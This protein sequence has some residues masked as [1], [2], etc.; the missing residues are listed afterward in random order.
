[1][2]VERRAHKHRIS[3]LERQVQQL[4]ALS[5]HLLSHGAPVT[6]SQ[7]EEKTEQHVEAGSEPAPEKAVNNA[8]SAEVKTQTDPA[9]T[10]EL[11]LVQ[12]GEYQAPEQKVIK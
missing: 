7:G 1:M 8:D 6:Q 11:H 12:N 9:A 2:R 4:R 3:E 10:I 5:K